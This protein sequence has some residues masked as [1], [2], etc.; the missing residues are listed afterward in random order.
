MDR[1]RIKFMALE[2]AMV[3]GGEKQV[4]DFI[5]WWVRNTWPGHRFLTTSGPQR[6]RDIPGGP[7]GGTDGTPLGATKV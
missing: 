1:P 4:Q 7:S 6:L 2:V 3:S 5:S